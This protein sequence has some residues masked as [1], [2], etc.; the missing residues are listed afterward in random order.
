MPIICLSTLFLTAA[1]RQHT[2]LD[3][4]VLNIVRTTFYVAV[5]NEDT[6]VSLMNFIRDEFSKD[7]HQYPA[8]ILAYYAALEGLR[9]RHASNPITKFL[10]VSRAVDKMNEA[11]EKAP[12]LLEGHFLR[13]SFFHQIPGI[14]GVG[15][16]VEGD[17]RETIVLLEGRDYGFVSEKIQQDMVG[18]LL[19]TDRLSPDQH[20][21]L[22]IL[23]EELSS[24]P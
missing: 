20:S 13:F 8:V 1:E 12:G 23:A 11:L 14:F 10:Y 6:T 21:R 15:G 3:M 7:H 9:G 19:R 2:E 22:E 4:Q 16:K 17:L 24:K 18:Y 5:D